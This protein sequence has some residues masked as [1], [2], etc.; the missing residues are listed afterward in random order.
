[1]KTI[2]QFDHVSFSYHLSTGP[3]IHALQ[4][5]SFSIASG[6]YVAIIGTNGSGKTT[7]AKLMNGLLLPDA[8]EVR[9]MGYPTTDRSR[10]AN[11]FSRIGLVFQHARD[12]IVASLVEEDTAFGPENLSLPRSEILARVDRSLAL[13]GAAHLKDRQTYLLS[14][15]E[16]QRVALAGVLAMQPDCLIFD[17][18]TTMLD[19]SSRKDLLRLMHN[20]NRQGFTVLHIT[21]DLDEVLNAERVLVLHDGRLVMDGEPRAIFQDERAL[22]QLRLGVPFLLHVARELRGIF[23]ELASFYTNEEDLLTALQSTPM[24]TSA[25][26]RS[27]SLHTKIDGGSHELVRFSHVSHTYMLDTPLAHT[28]LEDLSFSLPQGKTVGLIGQTGSGKSTVLQHVNAL[29]RPQQGIVESF[30]Y[31]LSAP[32]LDVRELRKQIGLVF[33]NPEA[34]FFETYVGDEIAYAARMLGYRGKLRDLV[35]T[36]MQTVGLDFEEFVDRPLHSLSGGQKRRVA[37]ASYLVVQ[38]GMLLLDEPFAGL[39]PATHQDMLDFVNTLDQ[40]EKTFLV[41]THNMRDLLALTR[42]VLVLHQG[43]LV[44]DGSVPD[45]FKQHELASWGMDIPL[46]IRVGNVLRGRGWQIPLD[47]V[48]WQEIIFWLRR[49]AQEDSNAVL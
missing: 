12:Q 37:L 6:E 44:F 48:D 25:L 46:E 32:D 1:M 2:L 47:V 49:S 10:Q 4:D 23:P 29:L 9:V 39:D 24:H 8:G 31:D 26:P 43:R 45:L 33:Q 40:Q 36:S 18:T 15:G 14:A 27:Q 35:R 19:P 11:V 13:C 20:L 22:H 38:P 41:S 21:H 3:S 42:R 30:G 7:L 5:V 34:Q 28:A 16:T 17:E